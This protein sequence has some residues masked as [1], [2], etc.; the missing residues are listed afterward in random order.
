MRS[1]VTVLTTIAPPSVLALVLLNTTLVIATG[2]RLE[3]MLI[4]PPVFALQ[5]AIVP[6]LTV[7][8]C[9]ANSK[10]NDDGR[11]VYN[12]PPEKADR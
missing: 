1:S 12:A 9:S 4:P 11:E 7:S 5:F 8:G 2:A 3:S 6:P 10:V